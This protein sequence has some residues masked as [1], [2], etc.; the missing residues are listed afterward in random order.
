MSQQTLRP[1]NARLQRIANAS[2]SW[3]KVARTSLFSPARTVDVLPARMVAMYL[4]REMTRASYPHI[5]SIFSRDHTTVMSNVK[6]VAKAME[7]DRWFAASVSNLR[8]KIELEEAQI[9]SC[10]NSHV[11]AKEGATPGTGENPMP[12]ALAGASCQ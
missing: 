8:S 2:C 1:A 3:F 7:E 6:A 11:G 5:G 12:P 4:C 10:G 9:A